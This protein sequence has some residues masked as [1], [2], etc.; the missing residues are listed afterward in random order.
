MNITNSFKVHDQSNYTLCNC[1]PTHT[2]S[3]HSLYLQHYY[4]VNHDGT[5][6]N[7]VY[8]MKT[9]TNLWR[10]TLAELPLPP[11]PIDT[12]LSVIHYVSVYI[13]L[14]TSL[15]WLPKP[16][17]K[18]QILNSMCGVPFFYKHSILRIHT[19]IYSIKL[20]IYLFFRRVSY[21]SYYT[22]AFFIFFCF[23]S[24][25]PKWFLTIFLV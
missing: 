17:R 19:H 24:S 25:C 11:L 8:H 9:W 23:Y 13:I 15:F 2:T 4:I 5:F 10:N 3:T 14:F 7:K 1:H 20:F 6:Y 18:L 16:Q 21:A 12:Q 22:F